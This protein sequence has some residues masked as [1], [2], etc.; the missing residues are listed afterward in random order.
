MIFRIIGTHDFVVVSFKV[1]NDSQDD[2]RDRGQEM[3]LGLRSLEDGEG[4][5]ERG[6]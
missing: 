5:E 2:E 6:K 4:V 3:E 1:N